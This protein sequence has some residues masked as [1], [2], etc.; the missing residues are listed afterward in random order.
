MTMYPNIKKSNFLTHRSKSINPTEP[1]PLG[2]I[3]NKHKTPMCS[4]NKINSYGFQQ[5]MVAPSTDMFKTTEVNLSTKNVFDHKIK[6]G[7]R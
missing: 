7:D 5:T 4:S 1:L 3:I 6:T 2:T